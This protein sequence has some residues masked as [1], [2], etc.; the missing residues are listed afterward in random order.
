[1][2]TVDFLKN[3]IQQAN[4][5][6]YN[7]RVRKHKKHDYTLTGSSPY[8][9]WPIK[10]GGTRDFLYEELLGLLVRQLANKLLKG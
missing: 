7:L 2:K 6:G 10:M 4:N 8:S 1:M 9:G 5:Q 3:L